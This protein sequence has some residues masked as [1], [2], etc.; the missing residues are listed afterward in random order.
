MSGITGMGTTFNLPNYHGELF[1]LTPSETPLLSAIGG[2]TGG[3]STASTLF[4]WQTSD[5]RDPSQPA[6]LEG[7]AAPTAQERVRAN[8]QNVCQIHQEKVSVSYTKQATSGMYNTQGSAPFRSADGAANPVQNELD[9]QTQQ[10][11]KSIAL[12]VNYSFWNGEFVNPT[13]NTSAR[14]TRGLIT[15]SSTN[16]T[17]KGTAITGITSATD[18][19]TK[20]SHGL[21]DGDKVVLTAVGAATGVVMGRV[22]YV[23]SSAANTFKLAATSGGSA[24]TV[25]TSAAVSLIKPWSTTLATSHLDDF[26]QG[27]WDNGGLGTTPILAANSTQKRAITK[28]YASAYGQGAVIAHG[29]SVGGVAVDTVLTDFGTFGI[30]LD[31]HIPKDAIV[32]VSLGELR[33]VFL[34]IPGKGVFFEE[35]LAKTGASDEV[36][37]Y[38]EIGLEYG[39][40]QHHGVLRGLAV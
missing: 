13:D 37:I 4:E 1:A 23:V 36:Q 38:G 7:A 6:V 26:V 34:D 28:A 30:M 18:T 17:N 31:R 33:P 11:L 5:L 40:E 8:V 15:A 21:S 20:T 19:F 22:Y 12:D 3:G 24:I 25:G 9:W 29:S 39:A 14:R 32:A 10:A 27:I 35:P 2:L 16:L